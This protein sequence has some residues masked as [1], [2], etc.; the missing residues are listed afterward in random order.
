MTIRLS[1][2]S[3]NVAAARPG[4]SQRIAPCGLDGLEGLWAATAG[5]PGVCVAVLD[6]PVDLAHPC[7]AGAALAR[8]ETLIEDEAGPALCH[9]THVASVIFG[10]HQGPVMGIAPDCRGLI[11]PVFASDGSG[12]LSP[13]A[14]IDLA[15]AITR[16]VLLGAQVINVS[17]GARD[18]AGEPHRLLAEAVRLCDQEGVLI[19]AA[20]GNDGCE[21]AHAPA[22]FPG[23]LA[24][25]AMGVDGAPLAFSNWGEP[26]QAR[27]ILA[28]GEG[29]LGAVPGGGTAPA[30]GTSSAT[31]IVSGVAALL[32]SLQ[33]ARRRPLDPQ[34]VRDAILNS[35]IGC[36]SQ[37]VAD[38]RRRLRGRLNIP[39]AASLLANRGDMKM[40]DHDEAAQLQDIALPADP[41]QASAEGRAVPERTGAGGV[42]P[43]GC[44]C[45]CSARSEPT[46]VYALG[47]IGSDFASEARRDSFLQQGLANPHDPAQLLAFLREHPAHAS[48][49]T[50]ILIQET[51]PTYALRPSGPFADQTYM[52]LRELLHAQLTEG[53]EQV[54][55]P[56]HVVGKAQLS[57]GQILPVIQPE[58]RGM[59]SWSTP[60]LVA[61]VLGTAADRQEKAKKG[62]V[63]EADIAN[64]LERV[65]YEIRNL[66]LSP[67]DRAIN[68]AA[69]N[70]FQVGR[71]YH[72]AIEA[73]LKLDSIAV[74]RSPLCRAESDCWDVKL[75]FFN[76]A[77]RLEQAREVYR[78]TVDVSDVVPVTV[79]N[80]RRWQVF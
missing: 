47:Q 17:G 2:A 41:H 43:A 5:D 23:V 21:C 58:V 30:T 38:C 72:S 57:S 6:G 40:P 70:A 65:Y 12:A 52:V 66:G 13:C 14:E 78:F 24:V 39:G 59:F 54:S 36:E 9:G 76:P 37:P 69:T 50:W 7:F 75:T 48:A 35:A 19:V 20:A 10:R 31:A 62:A 60:A 64:F 56:G 11:L 74:E 1:T 73:G 49:V 22:A 53:V 42:A 67:Q 25:G 8:L 15:R 27:G 29:I 4:T 79:G 18:F 55:I 77:R 33:R 71:V 68:F 46:L 44:G 28:P 45:A 63:T 32:L 26:Y 61:S 16:A 80:I 3:R 51:T 34:A